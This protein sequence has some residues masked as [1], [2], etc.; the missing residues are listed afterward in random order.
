MGR[1]K[2][3]LLSWTI[4]GSELIIIRTCRASLRKCSWSAVP[5]RPNPHQH[6]L[7]GTV[8]CEISRH[9]KKVSMGLQRNHQDASGMGVLII[10][11]RYV[12]DGDCLEDWRIYREPVIVDEHYRIAVHPAHVKL[13]LSPPI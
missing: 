9:V 7:F 4:S 6:S 5:T 13:R 3:L 8:P 12:L 10:Y 2:C 1:S 11:T